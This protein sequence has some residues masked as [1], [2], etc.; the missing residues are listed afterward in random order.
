MGGV[1]GVAK[2][3][4]A[5]LVTKDEMSLRRACVSTKFSVGWF[6]GSGI[7]PGP[8]GVT[9]RTGTALLTLTVTSGV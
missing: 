7:M 5:R 2:G 1:G 6:P 9:T 4:T 3:R 8:V